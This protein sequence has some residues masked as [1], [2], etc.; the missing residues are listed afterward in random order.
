M[1]QHGEQVMGG[2]AVLAVG[3]DDANQWFTAKI[4]GTS[5][6]MQ[7]YFTHLLYLLYQS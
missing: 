2:H 5:W 1:P 4:L 3:Y 6:G 7:G